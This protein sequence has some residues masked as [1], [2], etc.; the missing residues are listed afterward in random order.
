M[1][2]H[3]LNHHTIGVCHPDKKNK[4][5]PISNYANAPVVFSDL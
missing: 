2:V 3:N 5:G 4:L 1:V